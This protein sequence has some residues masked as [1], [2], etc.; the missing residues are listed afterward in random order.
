[1]SA[2]R[3][4]VEAI[5]SNFFGF[6]NYQ[7]MAPLTGLAC[8]GYIYIYTHTV[9]FSVGGFMS[10]SGGKVWGFGSGGG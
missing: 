3:S 1:M 5:A 6:K 8:T 10:T 2:L 7:I 4:K 9:A